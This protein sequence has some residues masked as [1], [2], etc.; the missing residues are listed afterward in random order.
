MREYS[1]ETQK[2]ID[3]EIA[4]IMAERYQ[5]AVKLLTEKR[6]LLD[7]IANRLLEEETMY[8]AE[9][10]DIIKGQQ[11]CEELEA[12]AAEV[13]ASTVTAGSSAEDGPAI[14]HSGE[15]N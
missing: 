3:D 6:T 4:R 10:N 1:E 14:D 9:F 5:N 2:Y 12:Q 7:Y 11:H 15:V 13:P 8:A